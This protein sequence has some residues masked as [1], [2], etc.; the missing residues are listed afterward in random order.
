[1]ASKTTPP[2]RTRKSPATLGCSAELYV[3]TH[4]SCL[5]EKNMVFS[6]LICKTRGAWGRS[7]HTSSLRAAR[8]LCTDKIDEI[9]VNIFEERGHDVD[10]LPTMSE[11]ELCEKLGQYDGMVVRSATKINEK[12]L[13]A[14][15]NLQVVGRAGVGV[16]NVDIEAAT[17]AGVMVMNTPDGN[18]T[19]TAQLAVSL[20]TNLVR[21]LPAGNSS[22]K[23][24]EWDR[25]SYSN[26]IEL[27]GKTLG[28]I[29]C[30][31]IGQ[32]VAHMAQGMGLKVIAY[33]PVMS[34]A[35]FEGVN[36]TSADLETVYAMSDFISVHA[37]LTPQTDK[38]LN[39][40]TIQ[41]CKDGVLIVNCARG[42]IVDEAALLEALNSGKVA[43]AALD[44]YT[45]EPPKEDLQEL[46]SHPKLICTPHLGASTE[47]AQ[48]NVAR[49]IAEQMCDAF[50]KKDYV[51]I[52]NV[53][54]MGASTVPQMKPFMRLAKTIG[55]MLGQMGSAPVKDVHVSTV[56]G[57]EISITTDQA[58]NLL[59]AK[60]L[61]GLVRYQV[62]DIV[63]D[64]ISA[65][66]IAKENNIK[67]YTD[68]NVP[69]IGGGGEGSYKNLVSVVANYEDGS[70]TK[71]TGSVF[72][73]TPHIIHID[74]N[75]ET[76]QFTFKP[77][78]DFLLMLENHNKPGVLREV[79]KV[80]H[81]YNVNVGSINV[82]PYK[83]QTEKAFCFA[84][85]DEDI[86]SKGMNSLEN[87]DTV[88][89]VMKVSLR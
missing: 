19:S 78:G 12:V 7:F 10:Y 60:V 75:G 88:D 83:D 80:L 39:A 25:K 18:T 85:V 43:G 89:R 57:R 56:G 28:L 86:P 30:G 69:D 2:F 82:A 27:T 15:S 3:Y 53:N 11:E 48:L 58:R 72:G 33:D 50:D 59:M 55:S 16:D 73:D 61:Q 41:K 70:Q 35:D 76:E 23:R 42:G 46:L 63:P 51:G 49:E 54:Y 26:G 5:L 79:L 62:S 4:F 9:C 38:L 6:R 66:L 67:S 22:V 45:S 36:I 8:V 68:N 13:K 31:R 20:L 21:K 34:A 14:A 71:I 29:G 84:V 65:P 77:E 87:L 64:F 32:D 17:K 37:P 1:M 24:G 81:N 44:V 47:E 74:S 40:E 52:L